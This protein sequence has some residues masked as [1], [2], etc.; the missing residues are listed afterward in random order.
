MGGWALEANKGGWRDGKSPAEA[1]NGYAVGFRLCV[2]LLSMGWVIASL[3]G[4]ALMHHVCNIGT[5]QAGWPGVPLLL[6]I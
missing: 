2:G 1:Q 4:W 6:D 5:L 3:G